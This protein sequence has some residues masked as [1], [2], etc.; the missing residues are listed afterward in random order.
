MASRICWAA[1][2]VSGWVSLEP[3]ENCISGSLVGVGNLVKLSPPGRFLDDLPQDDLVWEFKKRMMRH[4]LGK[5]RS[6]LTLLIYEL[7]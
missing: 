2:S 1:A 5:K 3:N 6:K 7:C 4:R